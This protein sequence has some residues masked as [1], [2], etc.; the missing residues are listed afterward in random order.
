MALT[1]VGG[2][3][4]DASTSK[5]TPAGTGAV[6]TNVQDK[7]R[8][9]VSVLDFIP[10]AAHAG[11]KARTSTTDV[12]T[13]IQAAIDSFNG[14]G[15]VYFPA[16]R[17]YV[18]GTMYL[19]RSGVHLVGAGDTSTQIYFVNAAGGTVFAGDSDL[20]ASLNTYTDC[21]IRNMVIGTGVSATAATNYDVG[22]NFTSFSYSTF[23]VQMSCYRTNGAMMEGQGNN[24]QS[25]YFSRF[26]S[27][28][29]IG[30]STVTGV[31]FK[32]G[33]WAGG[34]P[35]P[36]A[37]VFSD[38]SRIAG[39]AIPFDIQFGHGNLFTNISVESV[40]DAAFRLAYKAAA[41]YTGT[42]TGSIT[43]IG[44]TDTAGIGVWGAV[45]FNNGA[46]KVTSGAGAGQV[47]KIK[48][49][50][51]VTGAV[52]LEEPWAIV[53]SI[54]D[55]IE[56]Y[57]PS[58]FGNKIT[59]FRIEG[60]VTSSPNLI[61]AYPGATLNSSTKWEVTSTG[62][63]VSDDSGDVRNIW[64]SENR[65]VM[66]EIIENPGPSYS[67]D[68]YPRTSVLG[69]IKPAGNYVVEWV[70]VAANTATLGDTCT[71]T[72]DSGGTAA[73]G[74]SPSIEAILQNGFSQAM[75]ITGPGEK[76]PKDGTNNSIFLNVATGSSFSATADLVVTWCVTLV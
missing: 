30:S 49:A 43:Q 74:G 44:F 32:A 60:L 36:N 58:A 39:C 1:K 51:T 69:G 23:D 52:G 61:Q 19:K 6:T 71:V 56:L 54:G 33:L 9:D 55:T 18:T 7:L 64:Y 35:G 37:N 67:K 45:E 13:Y 21:A 75:A 17:Y 12:T 24:G 34:S 53:P 72:L 5:Y 40:H 50:S 42:I 76:T 70:K 62:E 29:M 57:K 46:V 15:T 28:K 63:V 16:G 11:I 10:E 4:W 8:A 59:N 2:S 31:R 68:I 65:L 48:T 26:S 41:D 47:R 27:S 14:P 3:V 25:P 22:I 20:G 73:G 38:F 66:T